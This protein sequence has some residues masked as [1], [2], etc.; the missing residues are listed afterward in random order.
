MRHIFE[1]EAPVGSLA[2]YR[3]TFLIYYII[4]WDKVDLGLAAIFQFKSNSFVKMIQC[5]KENLNSLVQ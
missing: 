1:P 2:I 5:D 4:K 3:K